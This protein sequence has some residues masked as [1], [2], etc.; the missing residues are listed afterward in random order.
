MVDVLVFRLRKLE[1]ANMVAAV[2]IMLALKLP[3]AEMAVRTT[4]ALLLNVLAYLTND[5]FDVH[6]DHE[7][8]REPEKTRFLREHLREAV[9][10]QV[11]LAALV[12]VIAVAFD[13]ELLVPLVLGAGICAIYSAKLKLVPFVDVVSMIAWGA[14]MTLVAFPLERTLGWVLIGQLGLFSAVFESIQVARDYEEDKAQGIL[15]TAVRLGRERSL[16]LARIFVVASAGYAA[17]LLHVWAGALMLVA[18]LLPVKRGA[19]STFWTQVRLVLGVAW[20][21]VLG[22][23]WWFGRTD[24]MFLELSA[25]AVGP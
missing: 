6:R 21:G 22:F 10:A 12:G 7:A 13:L 25:A 8:G 20:L 1:M 24:G 2:A 9:F 5:Y 19:E 17:C 15:T 16:W 18:A 11:G 14:A 23:V 4:C 3:F